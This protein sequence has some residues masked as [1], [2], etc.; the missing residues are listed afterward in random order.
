MLFYSR[1][2]NK[3]FSF[4]AH[5]K[6]TSIHIFFYIYLYE[7]I[8]KN[9]ILTLRNR[10]FMNV[11]SINSAFWYEYLSA[12]LSVNMY[13]NFFFINC[14]V[15]HTLHHNLQRYPRRLYMWCR[16]SNV[17][18]RP[19]AAALWLHC[20]ARRRNHSERRRLCCPLPYETVNVA[21]I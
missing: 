12:S 21:N 6:N 19:T 20:C 5:L 18:A 16:V 14:L 15:P 4:Y 3:F 7:Y 11:T 10:L 2:P 1:Q 17:L 9:K 8:W 13:F